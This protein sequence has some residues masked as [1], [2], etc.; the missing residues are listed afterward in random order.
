MRITMTNK[1]IHVI[2]FTTCSR[3]YLSARVTRSSIDAELV[4]VDE[5]VGTNSQYRT[6]IC[7]ITGKDREAIAAVNKS[8][9]PLEGQ[10]V[11]ERD[12]TLITTDTFIYDEDAQTLHNLDRGYN[13][14]NVISSSFDFTYFNVTE[15]TTLAVSGLK[16]SV[17][18]L[19][20][21]YRKRYYMQDFSR[22][23]ISYSGAPYSLSMQVDLEE[24][25][26]IPRTWMHDVHSKVNVQPLPVYSFLFDNDIIVDT[27]TIVTKSTSGEQSTLELT[28][29]VQ[30]DPINDVEQVEEVT[31]SKTYTHTKQAITVR[32]DEPEALWKI[33]TVLAKSTYTRPT[34]WHQIK[35]DNIK[36]NLYVMIQCIVHVLN[37]NN[38][39]SAS[40][41]L[42]NPYL[43]DMYDQIELAF[44]TLADSEVSLTSIKEILADTCIQVETYDGDTVL[45]ETDVLL[46]RGVAEDYYYLFPFN[47]HYAI[48]A[49]GVSEIRD[50]IYHTP[51]LNGD[52][53]GII[54]DT[55]DIAVPIVLKYL[56]DIDY[57]TWVNDYANLDL[58]KATS[59]TPINRY[60]LEAYLVARCLTDNQGEGSRLAFLLAE[61]GAH[62]PMEFKPNTCT[63]KAILALVLSYRYDCT[64]I[65]SALNITM[66]ITGSK[67]AP[68]SGT[69]SD[70]YRGHVDCGYSEVIDLYAY[71]ATL[72]R[73]GLIS[74]AYHADHYA[75]SLELK[76]TAYE[77]FNYICQDL[78]FNPNALHE[79]INELQT[80]LG[81]E[82]QP[83]DEDNIIL[84]L[85]KDLKPRV[86]LLP[87]PYLLTEHQAILMLS[88]M[89]IAIRIP[90]V[91]D[92]LHLLGQVK[93]LYKSGRRQR[94]IM[95]LMLGEEGWEPSPEDFSA[96]TDLFMDA[97]ADADPQPVIDVESPTNLAKA[98][99][100]LKLAL[101]CRGTPRK[102]L[103]EA[104]YVQLIAM[105]VAALDS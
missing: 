34:L 37:E 79:L 5:L 93:A 32:M 75:N 55:S 39:D 71:A 3:R 87:L 62:L 66:P 9:R 26:T 1:K 101:A 40:L 103:H 96:V 99:N 77:F 27:S 100:E 74:S 82:V 91:S 76:F 29:T 20:S 41:G 52:T 89:D 38:E 46:D 13:I 11:C 31:F 50:L 21:A 6:R 36:L 18:S 45:F 33:F 73:R 47:V 59:S 14:L 4:F 8:S 19:V 84:D 53:S 2:T 51:T 94:G 48:Q 43:M 95:H 85:I 102:A 86:E 68:T 23:L 61:P 67:D 25:Q 97:D 90:N 64:V 104:D 24:G 17:L 7:D 30:Q 58:A 42:D 56:K 54:Y 10:F 80:Y 72:S 60:I 16:T 28:T 63:D 44:E 35:S 69:G 105:A 81:K 78:P 12:F 65:S 88:S 70:L 22:T 57:R 92:R 83:L 98:M 15:P 49:L